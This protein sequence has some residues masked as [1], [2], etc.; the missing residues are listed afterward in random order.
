MG[1]RCGWVTGVMGRADRG[2]DDDGAN[3]DRSAARTLIGPDESG[4]V[5][6]ILY[7]FN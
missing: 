7:K 5:S 1:V 3:G 4:M 2:A 6:L